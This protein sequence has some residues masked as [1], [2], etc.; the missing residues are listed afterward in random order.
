MRITYLEHSGFVVEYKDAVLIFDYF[1][2]E[3]PTFSKEKKIY[4]FSSH[5]HADHFNPQIFTWQQ[6]YPDIT[7]ILSDDIKQQMPD[8]AEASKESLEEISKEASKESSGAQIL[9]VG[10]H[11]ELQVGDV[12]IETLHSTDEGVAFVVRLYDKV[13]YHAGDLHWWHWEGETKAYNAV[14]REE[15]QKEISRIEGLHVDVAFVVLDPR[16]KDQY[17]WGFDYYMKHTRT[18]H[19]FPMHMW[20]EYALYDRLMQEEYT[21]SYRNRVIQIT[22]PQ[23]TFEI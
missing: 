9:Y 3:V 11:E 19:V 8:D 21:A 16:L 20:G 5:V 15:Y 22:E 7:Y 6:K 13:I 12:R 14:M 10:E 17:D 18:D 2:G 4:V 23:Q 1:K